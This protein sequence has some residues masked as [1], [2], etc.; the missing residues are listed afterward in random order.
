MVNKIKLYRMWE[1]FSFQSW[2]VKKHPLLIKFNAYSLHCMSMMHFRREVQWKVLFFASPEAT[3]IDFNKRVLF[4]LCGYKCKTNT[5]LH[6]K[7]S[8]NNN[9]SNSNK[10]IILQDNY[11]VNLHKFPKTCQNIAQIFSR[12]TGNN[13]NGET[14]TTWLWYIPCIRKIPWEWWGWESIV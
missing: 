12:G 5:H 9:I 10:N 4:Q 14:G 2:K 1:T 8:C 7:T 11:T 13:K 3:S 6:R